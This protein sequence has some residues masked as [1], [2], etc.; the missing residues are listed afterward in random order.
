MPASS[1]SET[2]AS[3]YVSHIL[4]EYR[5]GIGVCLRE[6]GTLIAFVES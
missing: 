6:S 3:M 4:E 5:A 1:G 2:V